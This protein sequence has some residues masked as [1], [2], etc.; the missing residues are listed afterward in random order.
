MKHMNSVW[1]QQSG[2]N[3][4][5]ATSVYIVNYKDHIKKSTLSLSHISRFSN[6]F[7]VV[8][9]SILHIKTTQ[10]VFQHDNGQSRLETNLSYLLK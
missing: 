9:K 10:K 4:C 6:V 3:V 7:K 1:S 5:I 2:I 8:L